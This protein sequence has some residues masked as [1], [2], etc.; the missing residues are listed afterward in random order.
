MSNHFDWQ[1]EDNAE[2]WDD[3]V[4]DAQRPS[5]KPRRW[6][7]FLIL[8]MLVPAALFF[9]QQA[10]HRVSTAISLREEDIRAGFESQQQAIAT[11]DLELFK[12]TL[13]A[14][15]PG[16]TNTQLQLFEAG[17]LGDPWSQNLQQ[18]NQP[19]IVEITLVPELIEAEVK[20]ETEFTSSLTSNSKEPFKLQ[21]ILVFRQGSQRWLYSPPRA[22]FWGASTEAVGDLLTLTFPVRDAEISQRLLS[23]LD[24]AVGDMCAALDDIQCPADLHVDLQFVTD[25]RSLAAARVLS[26]AAAA[27]PTLLLQNPTKKPL[28]LPTPSLIG[29]PTDDKGYQALLGSYAPFVIAAAINKVNGYV[30][31]E[32]GLIY[33]ALLQK[34]LE[35]L[36][37]SALPQSE[38]NYQTLLWHETAVPFDLPDLYAT[39]PPQP[40][41]MTA[42]LGYTV[43]DYV[44]KVAPNTSVAELQR[45]LINQ[46]SYWRWLNHF[47]TIPEGSSGNLERNWLRFVAAKLAETPPPLPLPDQDIQL[48]CNGGS[49]RHAAIWRYDLATGVY[50]QE[51][52]KRPFLF[53]NPLPN[54]SGVILQERE[55]P[56]DRTSLILWQNK[57]ATTIAHL[58]L[59]TVLYRTQIDD[60]DQIIFSYDFNSQANQY[61]KLNMDACG[62]NECDVSPV[63]EPAAWDG[64]QMASVATLFDAFLAYLPERTT[65]SDITIRAIEPYPNDNSQLYIFLSLPETEQEDAKSAYLF[66][67]NQETQKLDLLTTSMH[68]LPP[69]DPLNISPDGQWVLF[70]SYAPESASA[71]LY[72]LHLDSST[73]QTITSTNPYS[74]PGYDWSADG[75]WLLRVE[76]GFIHLLAP[77]HQYQR[78]LVHDQPN[79][80]YAAWVNNM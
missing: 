20:I 68:K 2:N 16:W 50:T 37:W 73:T 58:P 12:T 42:M 78:L 8:A 66:S 32:H 41:S 35:T 56:A 3:A 77:E 69:F 21:N 34:Q 76:D 31:C 63:A 1:T 4:A 7:Y 17:L 5:S 6:P 51:S 80:N 44:T 33:Q 62:K 75:N 10:N 52:E 39:E 70:N 74:Y 54:D 57:H 38:N 36:G 15:Q 49:G 14:S 60:Q 45:R 64:E 29:T 27:V 30:C 19:Q 24:T 9:F 59:S 13:S 53:M 43:V 25:P 23:D 26:T 40:D 55:T 47:I 67:Y 11:N 65:E 79:C 46:S 22:E 48:L 72:L 71:V 18:H 61:H 28:R